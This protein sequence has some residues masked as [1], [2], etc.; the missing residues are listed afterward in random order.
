MRCRAFSAQ[1]R[2][3]PR[4]EAAQPP[5][6]SELTSEWIREAERVT[7]RIARRPE[8][9]RY[10]YSSRWIPLRT[11]QPSLQLADLIRG[12]M[13]AVQTAI[14]ALRSQASSLSNWLGVP[15]IESADDAR[16]MVHLLQL[17]EQAPTVPRIWL[18]YD[19]VARLRQ[20]SRDQTKQQRERRRLE[21]TLDSWLGAS[22]LN[23]RLSSYR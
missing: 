12:D 11:A 5:P 21:Q 2:H 13:G 7:E 17:L 1:V 3:L 15:T 9:F 18:N 10:H 8:E 16:A 23:N 6:T 14:D 19:A 20:L 22:P 4:L